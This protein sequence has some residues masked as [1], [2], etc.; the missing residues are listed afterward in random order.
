MAM[1]NIYEVY[2]AIYI[3]LNLD[4]RQREKVAQ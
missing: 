2:Y 4:D 3:Y 1:Y